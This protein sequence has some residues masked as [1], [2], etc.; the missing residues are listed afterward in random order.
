VN[1]SDS[2]N[3]ANLSVIQKLS[4][5]PKSILLPNNETFNLTYDIG[6]EYGLTVVTEFKIL[7]DMTD[8]KGLPRLAHF[9]GYVVGALVLGFGS[10]RGGRKMIV[11]SSIWVSGVMSIFQLVGNDFISFTFFQFFIG[12]FAGGVQASFLP[13][14]IE[15][16]PINYRTFYGTFFHVVICLFEI[17]LPW[18]A[19]SFRSWRLLQIF[20]TV[21]I[22]FTAVLH[23]FVYESIFWYLA[24]KEYDKAIQVLT[25]LAKRNGLNFESKFKQAK[26]FLHAKHSKATQVDIMPLLRLQDI[27]LLGQKYPQVDMAELQKQKSNSSKVRRF[28]NSLKG[29]SYRSNN[30]TYKPF[31]FIYSP[32]ML[33]YVFILAGLWLTN[34]FTD[35]MEIIKKPG[36]FDQYVQGTFSNLSCLIASVLA[37]SLALIK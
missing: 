8:Y 34:G 33:A 35:S 13:A 26:E 6:N 27:D 15:M 22:A 9:Y 11:L 32:T 7:C 36:D 3:I 21:P 19:K 29:D 18:L 10:D 30:T 24:H 14:I 37:V 16:F 12:L 25:K 17:V 2:N 20:V 23:W 4:G 5:P 28:L 1:C 31:D